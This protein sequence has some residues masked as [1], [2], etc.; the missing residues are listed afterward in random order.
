MGE[1]SNNFFYLKDVK[2]ENANTR[3]YFFK[4]HEICNQ[5]VKLNKKQF[6]ESGVILNDKFEVI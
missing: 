1:L 6:E 4:Y 3:E 5:F 2:F